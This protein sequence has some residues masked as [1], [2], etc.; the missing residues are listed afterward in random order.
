[1][2]TSEPVESHMPT[3]RVNPYESPSADDSRDRVPV[4]WLRLSLWAGA[5]VIAL[6]AVVVSQVLLRRRFAAME[7]ELPSLTQL[8]M[9]PLVPVALGILL[10]LTAAINVGTED[11]WQELWEYVFVVFLGVT[12]GFFVIACWMPFATGPMELTFCPN[13]SVA[14]VNVW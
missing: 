2:P 7:M 12:V 9:G 8:A 5:N 11:R 3:R 6:T 4:R 1:M 10:A 14:L 13:L